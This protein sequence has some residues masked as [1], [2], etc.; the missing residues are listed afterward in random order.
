M[1][2]RISIGKRTEQKAFSGSRTK[3]VREDIEKESS[4]GLQG[5]QKLPVKWKTNSLHIGR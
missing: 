4:N 2:Q 1:A 5:S 3:G